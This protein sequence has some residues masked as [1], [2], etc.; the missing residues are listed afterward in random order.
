MNYDDPAILAALDEAWDPDLGFL[1][2]LREQVFDPT[3]AAA[4]MDLLASIEIDESENISSEF[5]K[6]LWFAP[7]FVEWQIERVVNAGGDEAQVRH[8]S[9]AIRERVM[10]ILGTP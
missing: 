10:E 3:L 6:L 1:G 8:Y 5:V 7:L 2:R 4:Y 9:D